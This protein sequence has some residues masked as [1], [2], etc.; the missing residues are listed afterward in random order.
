[1][2]SGPLARYLQQALIETTP[3]AVLLH[4]IA[5]RTLPTGVDSADD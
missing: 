5:L 1:M 3:E 2:L 4:M